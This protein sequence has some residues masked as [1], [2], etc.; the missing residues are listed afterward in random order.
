VEAPINISVDRAELAEKKR[1][2]ERDER[3]RRHYWGD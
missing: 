2:D 3:E 1:Q